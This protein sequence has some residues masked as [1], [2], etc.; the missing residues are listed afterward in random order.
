MLEARVGTYP[1]CCSNT[2]ACWRGG[3]GAAAA[4]PARAPR[5]CFSL[6]PHEQPRQEAKPFRRR[7]LDELHDCACACVGGGG[8]LHGARESASPYI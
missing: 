8:G 2:A 5:V 3:R 1:S 6:R 4:A 7:T